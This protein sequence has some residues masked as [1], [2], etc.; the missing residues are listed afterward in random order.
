M[1]YVCLCAVINPKVFF[2]SVV[3]K[4]YCADWV[5]DR[6]GESGVIPL[7]ICFFCAMDISG[8]LSRKHDTDSVLCHSGGQRMGIL[9]AKPEKHL[10]KG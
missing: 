5:A 7:K 2:C 6:R 4:A 3:E 1:R 9:Q 8:S 10:L